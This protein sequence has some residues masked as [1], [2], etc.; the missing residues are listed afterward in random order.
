[1]VTEFQTSGK[2]IEKVRSSINF[3]ATA[4]TVKLL[5]QDLFHGLSAFVEMRI[6]I[7]H[8]YCEIVRPFQK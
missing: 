4:S 8:V 3:T 7:C 5:C 2:A 6:T 1:M